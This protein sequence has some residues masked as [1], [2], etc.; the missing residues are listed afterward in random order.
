LPDPASV[1]APSGPSSRDGLRSTVLSSFVWKGVSQLFFQA[2]RILVTVIL[3]RMLTPSQY[4]VAAMVL[5]FAS[6]VLVFSDLGFG[7]ALVQRKKISEDDRSTVFWTSI[8]AGALFTIV[9][10]GLAAPMASFYGTHEVKPLFAVFALSFVVTAAGATHSALLARGMNFRSLELRLMGGIAAGATVGITLAALGFGPWAIIGQQLA[11]ATLS[12]VLLWVFS[13]WRPTFAFSLDSLRRLGGFS[14][15][16]FGTRLLFYANRN[17]DNLLIARFLGAAALGAYSIAYT[18]MLAPFSQI[19]GP[20]A[21][22]LTPV[23]SRMQ[24]D[25]ERLA[26]A[27]IRVNRIVAAVSIPSLLGLAVVAPDLVPVLLG[28]KWR[29]A[30][31]VIQILS[32]VGL[33]QSL[34]RLNS[35]ILQARDWTKPLFRYS[36]IVLVA[37]VAGFSAGLHWG[38]VGV[39]VGYAISSTVVEPYY[40]LLTA[41]SIGIPLSRFL[42]SL[43]GVTEASLGMVAIIIPAR[44]LL[45][46]L[47]VPT[48]L[49]LGIVIS[50][51]IM[52]YVPLCRWREPRVVEELLRAVR[53]TSRLRRAEASP[54]PA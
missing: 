5:V 51:G 15:N 20:I 3:A 52:V 33:L 40:T 34:Q 47:Q 43:A 36:V 16:V 14:A 2:S 25:P 41:R 48:A 9:G 53:D 26:A 6:L 22:V 35:S 12:T 23:F 19:A 37:S 4:G 30:I 46:H 18:I 31:P 54:S 39:A 49:R 50:L 8:A 10:F 45:V 17:V 44:L 24:D 7:A 32:W 1:S 42:K 38:I 27:W 28:E 13:P 21:E 11:I 29:A